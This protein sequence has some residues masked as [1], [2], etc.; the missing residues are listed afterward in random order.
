MYLEKLKRLIIW[1]GWSIKH[2]DSERM[3]AKYKKLEMN[4][5]DT[6]K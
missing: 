2:D 6:N 5:K 3:T 1:N 4:I